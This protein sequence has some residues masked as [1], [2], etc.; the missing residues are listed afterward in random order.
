MFLYWL[1]SFNKPDGNQIFKFKVESA[2]ASHTFFV[3]SQSSQYYQ[4]NSRVIRDDTVLPATRQRRRFRHNPNWRRYLNYRRRMDERLSWPERVGG[5]KYLAQGYY[6]MIRVLRSGL[7]WLRLPNYDSDS[8]QTT[9]LQNVLNFQK[10]QPTNSVQ[11]I[12][13]TQCSHI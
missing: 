8:L 5:C 10:F 3:I 4:K 6:T 12:S 13:T 7:G 11:Y 1:I 9:P 2:F